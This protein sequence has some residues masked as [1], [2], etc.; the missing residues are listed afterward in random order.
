MGFQLN[1]RQEMGSSIVTWVCIGVATI[2]R[3]CGGRFHLGYRAFGGDSYPIVDH[4]YW[5]LKFT[6]HLPAEARAR[7]EHFFQLHQQQSDVTEATFYAIRNKDADGFR[8][9]VGEAASG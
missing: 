9:G 4:F 6:Q 3:N 2:A 5:N 8:D 7:F 1:C